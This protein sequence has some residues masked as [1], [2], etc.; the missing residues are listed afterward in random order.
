M[1]HHTRGLYMLN[2]GDVLPQE[3]MLLQLKLKQTRI[4][5]HSSRVYMKSIGYT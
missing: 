3:W 2:F 4:R 1:E 5:K